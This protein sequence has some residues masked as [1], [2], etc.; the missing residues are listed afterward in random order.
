MGLPPSRLVG[1][2]KV[3]RKQLK[4]PSKADN[5]QRE[6]KLRRRAE[7]DSGQDDMTK[8]ESRAQLK[9]SDQLHKPV[10]KE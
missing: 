6:E 1:N 5:C 8:L 2:S 10:S 3:S 4:R 7:E 9:D